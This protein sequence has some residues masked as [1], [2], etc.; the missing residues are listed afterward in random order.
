[1]ATKLGLVYSCYFKVSLISV[2]YISRMKNNNM[3]PG[4]GTSNSFRGLKFGV[5]VDEGLARSL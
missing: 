3:E 4:W 5:E 2:Y 1:M